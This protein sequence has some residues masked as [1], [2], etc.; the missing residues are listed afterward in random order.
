M[1]EPEYDIRTLVSRLKTA[2]M[3]GYLISQGWEEK[4]SQY[5]GQLYFE[6][7]LQDGEDK[8]ELY[9]PAST[10][11]ARY[12]THVMRA[13][14]K[15]CGIEDREPAEIARDMLASVVAV[16]KSALPHVVARVRTRN[17]GS[18]PLKVT[19]DLPSRE[20]VILPGEAIE[21][22]CNVDAN[23]LVEIE[24]RDDAMVIRG[25]KSDS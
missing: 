6:G 16:E 25:V 14:Y 18:T 5:E 9:L 12:H 17:S 1:N 22:V 23:G 2:H 3:Q 19:I 15:L 24:R 21:L 11:T 4:P 10:S 8:Y 20:H 13:L 7:N